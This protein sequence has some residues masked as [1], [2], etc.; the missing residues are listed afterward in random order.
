[1]RFDQTSYTIQI[2]KAIRFE[3]I[4]GEDAFADPARLTVECRDW[5]MDNIHGHFGIWEHDW[6]DNDGTVLGRYGPGYLMWFE[7]ATD[8]I[9]FKLRWF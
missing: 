1:V 2:P 8:A 9:L 4:Y 6:V 7:R 3:I 5:C